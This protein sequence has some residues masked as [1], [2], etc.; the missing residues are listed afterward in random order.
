MQGTVRQL[1]H[2]PQDRQPPEFRIV[3]EHPR[4]GTKQ[5]GVQAQTGDHGQPV[6]DRGEQF[7]NGIG[8][9]GNG[10]EPATRQPA[11]SQKQQLPAP[12]GQRLVAPADLPGKTFRGAS[13]VRHGSPQIR[14]AHGIWTSSMTLIQR[15]P[16]ALTKWP[17]EERT[18]SL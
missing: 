5:P 9:V 2:Q 12:V 8:G 15:S 18:G 7:D 13:V 11:A 17:C 10:N 6:T 16:L 14:P 3:I 1:C 4:I